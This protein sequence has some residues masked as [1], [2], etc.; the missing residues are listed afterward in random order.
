M[1]VFVV[2]GEF[3]K[4]EVRQFQLL[5]AFVVHDFSHRSTEEVRRKAKEFAER[6]HAKIADWAESYKQIV[7]YADRW[8]AENPCIE[9][10]KTSFAVW[11][12]VMDAWTKLYHDDLDQFWLST[13][14]ANMSRSAYPT[15]ATDWFSV[16]VREVPEE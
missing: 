6:E 11:N 14:A 4:P 2:V 13:K 15:N 3:G 8:V 16:E 12:A 1:S 5:R 7:A 10:G 9:E